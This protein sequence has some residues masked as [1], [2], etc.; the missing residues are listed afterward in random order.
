MPVCIHCE[1][2]TDQTVLGE[3]VCEPCRREEYFTC[4]RC[5]SVASNEGRQSVSGSLWCESCFVDNTACCARCEE[6]VDTNEATHVHGYGYICD[7][8]YGG[9]SFFT[10]ESCSRTYR[11][12][13]QSE[14]CELC[15]N[16]YEPDEDGE[17]IHSYDYKP[18]PIF[19]GQGHHFGVELEVNTSYV[20]DHAEL[21]L[22]Q[23]GDNV[24]LKKDG[25]IGSGFEIVTHPHTLDE[26]RKLWA[27]F[28]PPNGMTSYRSG[29]CGIHVHIE[30][31]GLTQLQIGKMLVFINE[32]KNQPFM[33]VIAQRTSQ[34]WAKVSKKEI[35]DARRYSDD[36][37]EALNLCNYATVEVRIFRGNTRVERIMKA[38][39]F[40]A[41]MVQWVKQASCSAL[42][43]ESFIKFVSTETKEYPNLWA[44]MVEK[45]LATPRK[46][47]AVRKV[48]DQ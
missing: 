37:Y 43:A 22:D 17:Y 12:G 32:E 40:C 14:D 8:C 30:R 2:E 35:S 5:E 34:R 26:H 25:S 33:Q 4:D 24:Y 41:A 39:E 18:R 42:T 16:C 13:R 48:E 1:A 31:K 28:T 6:Y 11:I 46:G 38:V 10:C 44:Y 47:V 19:F 36:R 20:S 45:N 21:V 27:K 15:D 3:P 7:S 9:G 29:E 23:L